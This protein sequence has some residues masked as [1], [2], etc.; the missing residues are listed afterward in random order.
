[1]SSRP[2]RARQAGGRAPRTGP[3]GQGTSPKFC[4]PMCAIVR[5]DARLGRVDAIRQTSAVH[6]IPLLGCDPQRAPAAARAR[7]LREKRLTLDVD[8]A[9]SP[10]RADEGES[11]NATFFVAGIE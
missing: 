2:D 1:M 6:D 9:P 8:P 10:G 11:T 7:I 4:P 3:G 5:A